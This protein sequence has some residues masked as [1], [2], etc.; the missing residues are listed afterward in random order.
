MKYKEYNFTFGA[1]FYRDKIDY[2]RD[3]NDFY[4]LTDNLEKLKS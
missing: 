3:K 1:V 2:T 4:P